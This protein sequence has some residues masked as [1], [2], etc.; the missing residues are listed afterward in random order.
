MKK[1]FLLFTVLSALAGLGGCASIDS[2]G[3]WAGLPGRLVYATVWPN[4]TCGL[5]APS[6][7]LAF[8]HKEETGPYRMVEA[9][10][11]DT[12]NNWA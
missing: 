11:Y 8:R 9:Q 4:E 12:G 2:R 1:L 3:T 7:G 6:F 5:K 10:V